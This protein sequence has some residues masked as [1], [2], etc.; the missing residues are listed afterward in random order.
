MT[1]FQDLR[2]AVRTALRDRAFSLVAVLTLALGI[3]ANTALFTIVNAVVLAPLPFRDPDRLVRVTVDFTRQNARDIGLSIPELFDL[4]ASGV[5]SEIAGSWPINANLTETDEPERVETALVDANYFAMLGIGAQVGRVFGTADAQPG[6]ADVAVISDALWKRRFGGDPNVIGRRIGIDND[7]YSI[8][9]VAPAAFRHPGRVNETDVDVWAPCGWV[10]SP[11]SPQ[12]VRRAYLLQGGLGRLT[13]GI[14]IAVA[15]QRIDALADR[16]RSQF[17]TDYPEAT[18]WTLRVIPLHDDLVGDVRPALLTLLGAVGFVLLIACANVANLLLA[19]SSA[20]RREIAIR[21]ALGAGRARIVGQ[22]LTESV[23]LATAGGVVGLFVAVWSVDGLVHLSPSTLPRMNAVAVDRVVLAFTAGLSIATGIVFGL[24]PAIH[25][26]HAALHDVMRDA[27]R[28][29][30]ASGSSTRLRG[31]LVAVEFAL[32]LVLLVAAALLVQS[33]WRLQRVT[34]GFDPDAVLTARLWLPQPNVPSA[35]PYFRHD[36]RVAFYRQVLDRIAALPGVQAAGGTTSLPLAGSPGRA[37]FTI[38]RRGTDAAPVADI[39]TAQTSLVT[40][41]Y[42]RALG[43][44]LVRGRLFDDHDTDTA[45]A[46]VVV[47]ESFAR[48]FL[49]GEAVGQRLALGSRVRAGGPQQAAGPSWWTIIGVVRDV[50]NDRLDAGATPMFYRSVLQVSNLNL[51]LVVRAQGDPARIAES[52]RREVRAVDPNEPVFGVRTMNA[53]VASAVAER[54]FT[55]QLLALFAATALALSAI[56]IYGVMAYFVTQRTHEIGVR[57]ALGAA[58]RDVLAMVLGQGAR[59][60]AAGVAA[61]IAGAFALTRAIGSM[62]F[63]VGPRD[64]LT[65]VSLAIVLTAVALV[66]CYVPA[67]RATR[68]DPIQA[69]RHE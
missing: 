14:S 68:V 29:A 34:L 56:G 67:R 15:Q 17:P 8:I 25:G 18:G 49:S 16:L 59:L 43:I 60:A 24:A 11:F 61:G 48:Q 9:G 33:V 42:F 38:E 4:R 12:P 6:I 36:A 20:R 28:S 10:A 52:I 66:A 57:M 50:K 27:T 55:M 19:R 41:G 63:G 2:Y 46:A 31:A 37:S 45:P 22:L 26:S 23:L 7:M 35:G 1:F 44:E 58:P 53:V 3:G 47:S 21:R 32:A 54:R 13:P 69:L 30:S 64:P 5:F 62:L 51:T 39:S 40:P 65:F